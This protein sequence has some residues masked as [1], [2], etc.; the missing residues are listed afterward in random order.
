MGKLENNHFKDLRILGLI[1][2]FLIVCGIILE[3]SASNDGCGYGDGGDLGCLGYGFAWLGCLFFVG[4]TVLLSIISYLLEIKKS[5]V[6]IEG[7]TPEDE[8]TIAVYI[9]VIPLIVLFGYLMVMI[10]TT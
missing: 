6:E 2:I 5:E 9:Y 3:I 8:R 7:H 10:K 4:L 1:L